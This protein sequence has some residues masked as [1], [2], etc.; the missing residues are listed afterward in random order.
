MEIPI[1]KRYKYLVIFLEMAAVTV[2]FLAKLKQKQ[3]KGTH[4]NPS[5]SRAF[6]FAPIV[7]RSILPMISSGYTGPNGP[8]PSLLIIFKH[9]P[10]SPMTL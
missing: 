2:L 10:Q 8:C 9:K 7:H 1:T 6:F 5:V 3:S 4:G